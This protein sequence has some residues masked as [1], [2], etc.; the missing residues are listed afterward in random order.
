MVR[1]WPASMAIF[2]LVLQALFVIND[3]RYDAQLF[4]AVPSEMQIAAI[5][6]EWVSAD[7]ES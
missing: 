6:T 4:K 1:F 5:G 3:Q 7:N 2:G